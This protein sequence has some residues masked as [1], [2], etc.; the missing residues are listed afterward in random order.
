MSAPRARR[1]PQKKRKQTVQIVPVQRKRTQKPR[2]KK[3][4]IGQSIIPKGTFS[5]IGSGL[6]STFGP[7]GTM[8]GGKA[9]ELLSH[10]TGFGDYSLDSNSVMTGGLT[11]PQIIN[12]VNNGGMIIRHREYLGDLYGNEAAY[13]STLYPINPGQ[14][15]SFPWLSQVANAFEEYE[16][17]GLV[18]E[19]KSLS[20]D[21]VLSSTASTAL[22]F[23]AMATQYNAGGPPFATKRAL[24]NYE[25]SNSNKPSCSFIHPIE[26][27]RSLNV[28]THLYVRVGA[29][30]NNQDVKTY[31]MGL[32]NVAVGGMQN[33]TGSVI[34][35]LWCTYE[36]ELYHP[37]FLDNAGVLSDHFVTSGASAANPLGTTFNP[38][39]GNNLGIAIAGVTGGERLYFP[40][41]DSAGK[42]LISV[43]WN[44]TAA[45]LNYPIIAL[46]GCVA[47]QLYQNEVVVGQVNVPIDGATAQ[48]YASAIYTVTLIAENASILFQTG[49]VLPFSGFTDITVTQ[50]SNLNF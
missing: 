50:I 34:G 16:F 26:C 42:Y 25:F 46:T 49:S 13:S 12:S 40:A 2:A 21:A 18:Y 24:E 37:K 17:R 36:I 29:V 6:G 41:T 7:I 31:D 45:T 47:F 23:V 4:S 30:P 44:G 35:E 27:K 33:S 11:P 19:F 48:T 32:L 39:T 20:S 38:S 9:G 1:A 3:P 22:G 8:L 28:D 15:G 10:I 43:V 5:A 14:A